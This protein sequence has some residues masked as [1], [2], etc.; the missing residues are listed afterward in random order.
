MDEDK[1]KK[2]DYEETENARDTN[3]APCWAKIILIENIK[4]TIFGN[5]L[6]QFKFCWFINN[7]AKGNNK[8]GP[9]VLTQKPTSL[10]PK[11]QCKVMK[12]RIVPK[13]CLALH[14]LW[15]SKFLVIILSVNFTWVFVLTYG[16]QH[17]STPC[18]RKLISLPCKVHT[19]LFKAHEFFEDQ[20]SKPPL[21]SC[22]VFI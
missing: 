21:S 5:S 18:V 17:F 10:V 14:R 15:T 19:E 20:E 22:S 11:N 2:R 6:Y 4:A 16:T 12:G 13:N 8:I 7:R 9:K 3:I 1:Y